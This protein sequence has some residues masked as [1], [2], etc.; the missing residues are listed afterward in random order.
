M[1]VSRGIW[2][3]VW[4]TH[5]W[6]LEFKLPDEKGAGGG[7]HPG[8]S[9]S[10]TNGQN[11]G[12]RGLESWVRPSEDPYRTAVEVTVAGKGG[13]A[14]RD[15]G[16]PPYSLPADPV[17]S[18]T[19]PCTTTAG[20]RFLSNSLTALFSLR[21]LCSTRKTVPCACPMHGVAIEQSHIKPFPVK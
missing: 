4:N 18:T 8:G 20:L 5:S 19:G 3:G 13:R 14:L 15:H 7:V 16:S 2:D 11:S 21:I 10:A 1:S 6:H 9:G 17:G 12:Q